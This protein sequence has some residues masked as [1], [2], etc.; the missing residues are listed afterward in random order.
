MSN[1]PNEM[2]SSSSRTLRAWYA[3]WKPGGI[4]PPGSHAWRN[5]SQAPGLSRRAENMTI[6]GDLLAAGLRRGLPV[7][8][9]PARRVVRAHLRLLLAV[10][11]VL[12]RLRERRIRQ[13]VPVDHDALRLGTPR[14]PARRAAALLRRCRP[15][16]RR[17][18][19]DR[20]V[21]LPVDLGLVVATAGDVALGERVVLAEGPVAELHA[22]GHDGGV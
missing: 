8:E 19:D 15:C 10:R 18:D 1:R 3:R 5:C 21:V 6:I 7:R 17:R 13:H 11:D 20:V 16:G 22:A 14:D 9:V 4:A 12:D 2:T